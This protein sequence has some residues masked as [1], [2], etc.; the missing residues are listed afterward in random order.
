MVNPYSAENPPHSEAF[1]S[2]FETLARRFRAV[3]ISAKM[4]CAQFVQELRAKF[5]PGKDA[6]HRRLR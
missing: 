2:R 1:L 4:I 5:L 3:E 6:P